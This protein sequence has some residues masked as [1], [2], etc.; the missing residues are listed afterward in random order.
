[1][2]LVIR[3]S[4][5]RLLEKLDVELKKTQKRAENTRLDALEIAKSAA[6]SPSQSGDREHAV[7]QA[8]IVQDA[9]SLLEKLISDIRQE[10]GKSPPTISRPN[11]FITLTLDDGPQMQ[12]F[13]TD[14]PITLSGV[15]MVSTLSPLGQ[16]VIR[17]KAG[18]RFLVEIGGVTKTGE[19]LAID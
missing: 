12:L 7:N 16:A 13:L 11:T 3:L 9:Q 1:M 8:S 17:R 4:L 19:I 15:T 5:K 18:E 6:G 10:I 2:L 14:T